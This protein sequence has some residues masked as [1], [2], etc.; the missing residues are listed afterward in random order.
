MEKENKKC[1][2]KNSINDKNEKNMAKKTIIKNF[3]RAI[4]NIK[5]LFQP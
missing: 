1:N 3:E 5:K 4:N 2:I